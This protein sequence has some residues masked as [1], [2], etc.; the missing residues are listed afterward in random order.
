MRLRDGERDKFQRDGASCKE[1]GIT[2]SG[3]DMIGSILKNNM[4][5]VPIAL[6]AHGRMGS[7]IER[8]LYGTDALPPPDFILWM[9]DHMPQL[10]G[11]L[12]PPPS[13]HAEYLNVLILFGDHS[14]PTNFMA[15]LTELQ[16]RVCGLTNNLVW[17]F[18]LQCPPT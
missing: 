6:T 2:L 14:I 11:E 3:D 13:S 17:S 9:I 1:T 7:L 4:G 15:I 5:F 16:R 18:L 8:V 10:L 12:L